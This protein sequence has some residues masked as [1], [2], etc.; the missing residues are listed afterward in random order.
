VF[1]TMQA[2]MGSLFVNDF[3][4]YNR[5]FHVVVLADTVFRAKIS[6]MDKYYVRNS[7]G[8]MVPLSTV[9]TY[10]AIETAP[11]IQHF[12]IFRSAEVDGNPTAGYSS[13]EGIEALKTLAARV[14][15]PGY[16]ISFPGCFV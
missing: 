9:I 7:A 12:N 3:T 16:T 6:D 11:L 5:T 14:L 8:T 4:L 10:K 2:Y 15:P 1:Q 13:G